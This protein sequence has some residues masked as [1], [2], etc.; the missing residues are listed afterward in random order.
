MDWRNEFPD[1]DSRVWL[2][3]AHQGVLPLKAAAAAHDAV[4]WKLEPWRMTQ[5]RFLEVPRRV[6]QGVARL[7]GADANDVVL[8]NGASH[9]QHLWADGLRLTSADEVLLMRGDFPSTRL[10]WL[11]LRSNGVSVRDI[12]SV[13]PVPTAQEVEA[14][15]TPK[16]RVVTLSWVHSFSGLVADLEGIGQLCRDR[17]IAFLVNTTQGVGAIP[18]S[19]EELPIDAVTNAGWK[20]LCGP[21]ATGFCWMRPAFR[22]KLETNRA[23]WQA[24][25]TASDLAAGG[26]P[27]PERQV[28]A[29]RFDLFSPA[30]FFSYNAW[31]ESLELLGQIGVDAIRAHDAALVQQLLDGLDPALFAPMSAAIGS[32]SIVV[33]QPLTSEPIAVAEGMARAGFD[34]AV[35]HGRVRLAPHLYNTAVQIDRALDA[36]HACA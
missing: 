6:R 28:G 33:L 20:W 29:R 15:L 25:Q 10:P 9:G 2:N 16:T 32:S 31:A 13:G 1:H 3:T 21:Y 36:L 35:R 17:G 7:I 5:E 23:Y 12:K 19:V 34:V 26:D 14:A 18:L 22:E 30:N 24:F 11:R 8:A 27:D 4:A